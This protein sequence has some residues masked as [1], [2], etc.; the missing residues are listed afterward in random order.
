MPESTTRSPGLARA[1]YI[2]FASGLAARFATAEDVIAKKLWWYRRGDEVPDRQW[3]DV[4]GVLRSS[5]PIL[6]LYHC[7]RW[8]ADLGV[9][10]LLERELRDAGE[11]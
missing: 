10:D 4:L 9:L 8:A 6:D 1:R 11:G 3:R 2:E 7:R 5:G